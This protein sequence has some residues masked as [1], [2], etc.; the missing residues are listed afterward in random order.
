MI[1]KHAHA[2]SEAWILRVELQYIK[3]IIER[4][5]IVPA[6]ITLTKLHKTLQVVMGWENAHLHEFT[7]DGVRY[8]TPDPDFPEMNVKSERRV[9]LN[10]AL[11]QGK[12]FEYLYDFGDGWLHTITL[13]KTLD[14]WF[15][16]LPYCIDGRNACPPED[17]GGPP[18]Y[19]DFLDAIRDDEHPD[20][21]LL[22]RW[23]GGEFDP[24]AFDAVK[25]NARL[26]GIKP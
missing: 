17:V 21:D 16:Q 26:R 11:R 12:Q 6:D 8:G 23:Y 9:R 15:D 20:H 1:T 3:P 24:K 22:M 4:T 13:T 2:S 7:I 18:G 5:F 25:L 19:K 14:Q 10:D